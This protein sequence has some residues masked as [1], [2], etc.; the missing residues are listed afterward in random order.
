MRDDRTAAVK[1][2]LGARSAHA[3]VPNEVRASLRRPLVELELLRFATHPRC[4]K[5]KS[6]HR[7]TH[8]L[9]CLFD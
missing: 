9:R 3:H 2:R 4:G 1:A 7:H 5:S 6:T 8:A